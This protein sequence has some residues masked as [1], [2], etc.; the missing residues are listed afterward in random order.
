MKALTLLTS[1]LWLLVASPAFARRLTHAEKVKL[2]H[3]SDRADKEIKFISFDDLESGVH[4]QGL[5]IVFFGAHCFNPKYLR[6]QKR[7]E[8]AGLF[9]MGFGMGKV[10]CALDHEV[11]CHKKHHITGYPTLLV[12]VNGKLLHE[13]PDSDEEQPLFDYIVRLVRKNTQSAT[14]VLPAPAV[15]EED[16]SKVIKDK[17]HE[18]DI[19]EGEADLISDGSSDVG[20]IVSSS[21]NSATV[22]LDVNR[23][24]EVRKDHVANRGVDI[25][26]YIS[27]ALLA[28]VI[29]YIGFA[30]MRLFSLRKQ[31]YQR[32]V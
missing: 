1:L 10:E 17:G 15:P 6:V 28:G 12:Y 9:N 2:R 22:P 3:E 23:I 14:K 5:Y 27:L 8:A 29:F 16:P 19:E 13:Y 30:V 18:G 25:G 32:V 7:V 21:E 4:K 20:A 26:V 31:Q 11:Y 24:D